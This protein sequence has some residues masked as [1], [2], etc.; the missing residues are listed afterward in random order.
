ME[1][2]IFDIAC[3]ACSPFGL[4]C[5]Q[6]DTPIETSNGSLRMHFARK[7]NKEEKIKVE[8]SR[9][10]VERAKQEMVELKKHDMSHFLVNKPKLCYQCSMCGVIIQHKR[11][12]GKHQLSNKG[13]CKN[14]TML[15]KYLQQTVC[16]RK[17][18]IEEVTNDQ[19]GLEISY[20]TTRKWVEEIVPED[21]EAQSYVSLV[22]PF[23]VVGDPLSVIIRNVKLI[24]EIVHEN[25]II[26]AK[27][28]KDAKEWMYNRARGD[29]DSL[30][31]NYRRDLATFG[32]GNMSD[33]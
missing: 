14:A 20:K 31:A 22:H 15:Q 21:E 4:F 23:T 24:D 5:V 29:T 28:I 33:K 16:N 7:H 25:E 8:K 19:P 26:L 6:C 13:L 32:G 3:L 1:R 9:K 2:G 17:I 11:S 18:P 27:V 30:P 12:W 10:I